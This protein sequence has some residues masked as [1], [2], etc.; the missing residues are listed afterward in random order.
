L[1]TFVTKLHTPA[2]E[3]RYR[4]KLY[5]SWSRLLTRNSRPPVGVGTT[6]R[7]QGDS[8]KPVRFG[9]EPI[10]MGAVTTPPF[11]SRT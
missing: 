7:V 10:G 2:G 8:L 9:Y 4:S 6:L 1:L 11:T 3:R 5:T